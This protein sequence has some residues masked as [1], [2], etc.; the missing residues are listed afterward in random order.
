MDSPFRENATPDVAYNKTE[1]DLARIREQEETK[2]RITEAKEKTKQTARGTDGY[3]VVRG[4]A[5]IGG[6]VSVIAVC[7][8]SYNAYSD[9]MRAQN[10]AAF[11]T[12]KDCVETEEV[13]SIDN[14]A[15]T[16]SPGGWY[17]SNPT[18]RP[19]QLLIHCHCG[20]RPPASAAPASSAP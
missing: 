1:V 6:A 10:P 17:E 4:L 2:R 9:K 8:A 13:I 20:P 14:S 15:R 3:W 16:C 11:A 18:D 19:G 5:I 7:I 12:S